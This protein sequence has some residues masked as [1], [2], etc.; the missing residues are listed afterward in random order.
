[1]LNL[2]GDIAKYDAD[3]DSLLVSGILSTPSEDK[4]GEIVSP[5]AMRKALGDFLLN[6]TCREMHQPIAAGKPLS[7]YVDEDGN[8]HVTVKVVDKGTIAKVKEGILKGFSIGGKVL[9]KI[10][11]TITEL[12]L[13]DASLVDVPANPQCTIEIV[14]FDKPSDRC[15]DPECKHHVEGHTKK[16]SKCMAKAD[17]E[18]KKKES[19]KSMKKMLCLAMNLPDTTSD[20]DLQKALATR[21]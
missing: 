1:M 12:T 6:G 7:A 8:T 17:D 2:Y 16:C 14:K 3:G 5:D 21:L 20:E 19:E 11:K 13:K 10:G 18:E 4:Q 15:S 9:K